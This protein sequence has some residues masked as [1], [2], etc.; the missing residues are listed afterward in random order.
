MDSRREY[1]QTRPEMR[2]YMPEGG[3]PSRRDMRQARRDYDG[4]GSYWNSDEYKNS[5]W[6]QAQTQF[7]DAMQA[8]RQDMPSW[9]SW[10][11]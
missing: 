10:N 9:D 7:R 11:Q 8:W 6:G 1:M 5:D 3:M 4:V 2:D